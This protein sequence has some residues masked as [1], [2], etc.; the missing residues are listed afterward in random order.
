MCYKEAAGRSRPS[1]RGP[2]RTQGPCGAASRGCN[3]K[4][5]P[6]G[7]PPTRRPARR[8]DSRVM[9][10]LLA[11][12]PLR[13]AGPYAVRQRVEA[14][15]PA[16]GLFKD[17]VAVKSGY[18][19]IP[20]PGQ[21]VPLE[22]YK[23]I[24]R[25][26]NATTVEGQE[27]WTT[28]LLDGVPRRLQ[29]LGLTGLCDTEVNMDMLVEEV[30]YQVGL[31][32]R[33]AAWSRKSAESPLPEGVVVLH[34]RTADLKNARL[35]YRTRIFGQPVSLRPLRKAR[36]PLR[37]CSKCYGFHSDT[38]CRRQYKCSQCGSSQHEGACIRPPRC[39]NCRGPHPSTA[40]DCPA[41]P[42]IRDGVRRFP[43]RAQM[44]EIR[45][46]GNRDWLSQHRRTAG[47]GPGGLSQLQSQ[48]QPSP[49]PAALA[50]TPAVAGTLDTSMDPA[51]PQ[52]TPPPS[53]N[54]R[55]V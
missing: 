34:F 18:A 20:K 42:I 12:H 2:R 54:A 8:P 28:F 1:R 31:R 55:Q 24:Q 51:A 19:L 38:A 45:A 35:P 4:T 32:P 6:K 52:Q 50:P 43:N 22:V 7:P 48:P 44:R 13:Q 36:A 47:A 10:R 46:A 26:L 15:T 5:R 14:L 33:R 41:R 30:Q 39:L 23:E 16:R 21:Q 40:K 25:G 17:A 37:A 27:D 9:V 53:T 29:T 3:A 11:D 49:S